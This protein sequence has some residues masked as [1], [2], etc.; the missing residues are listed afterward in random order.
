MRVLMLGWEFPPFISGGLGT[1][2]FGLTRALDR[3]G[4]E[5]VFVLPRPVGTDVETHVRLLAPDRAPA[6][7]MA[8]VEWRAAGGRWLHH[9]APAPVGPA[10]A[11]GG[12]PETF[13]VEGLP[14]A[15]LYALPAGFAAVGA[16]YAVAAV[17]AGRARALGLGPEASGAAATMARP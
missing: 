2:C 15:R 11:I 10:G 16:L 13:T 12:L 5:V 8:D 4:H 9:E 17:A 7:V 14:H 6:P 3:M 1:A